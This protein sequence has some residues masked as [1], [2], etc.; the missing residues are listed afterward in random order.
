MC[1]L[2][3]VFTCP[4]AAATQPARAAFPPLGKEQAV[5]R[6]GKGA[7]KSPDRVPTAGNVPAGLLAKPEGKMSLCPGHQNFRHLLLYVSK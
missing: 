5:N 1:C 3:A 4:A 7:T 2:W 6:Q